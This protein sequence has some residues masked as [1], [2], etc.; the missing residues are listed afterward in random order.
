[1]DELWSHVVSIANAIDYTIWKLP[2]S[3]TVLFPKI[4]RIL[5][6]LPWTQDDPVIDVKSDDVDLEMEFLE[7]SRRE[8]LCLGNSDLERP[9]NVRVA[10]GGREIRKSV[11][12][13]QNADFVTVAVPL[14]ADDFAIV[15]SK[16]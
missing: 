11:D 6:E 8:Q 4:A 16:W 5:Y 13:H 1:M 3:S 12:H 15:K 2:G 7:A 10:L 9:A 14:F